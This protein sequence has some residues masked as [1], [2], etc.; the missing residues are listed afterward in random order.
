MCGDR[1]MSDQFLNFDTFSTIA[2]ARRWRNRAEEMR[3]I[4]EEIV[5]RPNQGIAQRLADSYERLAKLAEERAVSNK[6]IG[7]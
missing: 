7:A 3:M 2:D 1:A 4:A 5:S 6:R